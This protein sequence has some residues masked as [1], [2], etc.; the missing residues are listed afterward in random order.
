[1]DFIDELKQFSN[2]IT[3]LKDNLKT[4]EATKTSLV[5]PFFQML[6]YDVFNP[7][8][9]VPEFVADVGTKKGEK[10]D[11][12]IMQN[13]E[14][15]IIVEVKSCDTELNSKHTNQLF[16]YFS[17]TKAKFGVL[18]NGIIYRFFSDLEESNKMDDAPFLEINLSDINDNVT[19]ELKR[20]KKDAFDIKGILDSASELKYTAMI[21]KVLAEQ[22]Q[23]PSDQFIK[24][25][26]SKGVYTG[27]KTQSIIDKFRSIVKISFNEY[28]NDII[29]EKFKNVMDMNTDSKVNSVSTTTTT[30]KQKNL[31]FTSEELDILDYVKSLINIDEEVIYKKTD[32]YISI[33]LGNNVRKWLCRI[34]IKQ[35]EKTF[36]LHKYEVEDYECE[37]IFEEAYQLSQIKDI[38][39]KVAEICKNS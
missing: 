31:E 29:N 18:T 32:R 20:F 7:F 13:N 11:Y 4:E 9:F 34:Y 33:Q 39:N 17:V 16:R 1:M 27:V 36:V 14:P 15:I 12:A 3:M 35:N 30:K 25:I 21:K 26:L 19:T 10:V 6:G 23:E 2:R 37:Y 5:L 8:E 38:I 28:I 22:L 24:A